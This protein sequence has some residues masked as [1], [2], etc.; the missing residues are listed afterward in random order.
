MPLKA[1]EVTLAMAILSTVLP[2][3]L[4]SAGIRRIGPER[5]ALVGAAGPVTTIIL[6][7][8]LLGEPISWL[9]IAGS[10]LVLAGV[11]IISQE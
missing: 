11:L 4:L 3:F 7:Y 10:I 8:Y 5:A 2:A 1:Y 9:Q 6:A